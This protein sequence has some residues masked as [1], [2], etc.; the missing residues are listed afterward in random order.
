MFLEFSYQERVLGFGIDMHEYA[1]ICMDMH[2]HA[3]IF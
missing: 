3:R 1:W 2:I